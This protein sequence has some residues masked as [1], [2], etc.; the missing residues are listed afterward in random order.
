M[1]KVVLNNYVAENHQL[2]LESGRESL[3]AQKKFVELGI[4]IRPII[5]YPCPLADL[6]LLSRLD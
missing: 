1:V 2:T 3:I 5:A 6:L 4:F